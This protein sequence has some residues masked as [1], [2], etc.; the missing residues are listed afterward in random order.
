M[1][2]KIIFTWILCG[3]FSPVAAFANPSGGVVAGGSADISTVGAETTIRQG[4][5]RLIINWDGFDIKSGETTRFIQPSDHAVALNRVTTSGQASFIDGHLAA[6]GKIIIINPNGM[7]FGA[8]ARVNVGSLVASSANIADA[9]FLQSDKHVFDHSGAQDA[10]V[11]NRGIVTVA[12]GGLAALVAP[13]VINSGIIQG[14]MARINLAGGDTFG[15]DLYG[16]GLYSIEAK[17]ASTSRVLKVTHDGDI[18]ADG[19]RVVLTAAAA[20]NLV[21]SAVNVKGRI[22]ARSLVERNGKIILSAQDTIIERGAVLRADAENGGDGGFIETSAMRRLDVKGAVVSTRT[23]QGKSGLW[24]IDRP[25]LAVG[26]DVDAESINTAQS[27]IRLSSNQDVAF[28]SDIDRQ[29]AGFNLTVKAGHDIFVLG[30]AIALNGGGLN[31]QAG[32]TITIDNGAHIATKG[33]AAAF[34]AAG[35]THILN[36]SLIET[37]GG[38]VTLHGGGGV[39]LDHSIIGTRGGDVAVTATRA[40][41]IKASTLPAFVRL[42]EATINTTG[43]NADVGAFV[44]EGNGFSAF[45]LNP[46]NRV[47][48]GAF[49]GKIAVKG[50]RVSGSGNCLKAGGSGACSAYPDPIPQPPSSGGNTSLPR[51][52][53]VN[54]EDAFADRNTLAEGDGSLLADD[55]R[56]TVADHLAAI[57]PQA[58]GD[59]STEDCAN[60]F[61]NNTPCGE[62]Y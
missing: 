17:P 45:L 10:V 6:N 11:E 22:A 39:T 34:E 62:A 13:T 1:A 25:N 61:L 33:G 16:D 43:G 27:N 46:T 3:L 30:R 54:L 50:D 36:R 59:L 56:S 23:A 35:K 31:F 7:V 5:D 15:I 49:G 51:S 26:V 48:D 14:R 37:A 41:L 21:D 19:G 44:I 4:T 38:A 47:S 40:S 55:G 42:N 9:A 52:S 29:H 58:G 60:A 20:G 53:L 24:T 32:N 28:F 12:D 57:E 8:G 18:I 2:L